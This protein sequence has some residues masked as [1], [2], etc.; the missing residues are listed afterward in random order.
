MDDLPT[1]QPVQHHNQ[2]NT[3]TIDSGIREWGG[4]EN[5]RGCSCS[6]KAIKEDGID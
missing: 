2:F 3:T 5:K 6:L 1:Q 4:I